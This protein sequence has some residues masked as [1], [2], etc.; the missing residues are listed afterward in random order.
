MTHRIA[1]AVTAAVG[2]ALLLAG[3]AGSPS[4]TDSVS[5]PAETVPAPESPTP[6]SPTSPSATP[7][8]EPTAGTSEHN[9]AALAGI[10]TAEAATE[11]TAFSL[12]WSRNRWEIELIAGNR[13]HEV[14]LSA[15]GTTITK[16]EAERAEAEDRG[17][18]ARAEVPMADAI[19]TALAAVPDASVVEVDLDTRRSDLV[20]EVDTTVGNDRQRTLVNAVT[21]ELV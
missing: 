19:A 8:A 7:S 21:G 1:R 5:P 20:W 14:Y 10:Q 17:L 13:M 18:L 16:Q 4:V 11:G 6:E 12:D 3:C 2:T 15:D 9:A